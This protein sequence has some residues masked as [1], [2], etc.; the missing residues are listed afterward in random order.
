MD[1]VSS[2]RSHTL[3]GMTLRT[4]SKDLETTDVLRPVPRCPSHITSHAG[5]ATTRHTA[6]PPFDELSCKFDVLT[7]R[8]AQN[9]NLVKYSPNRSVLLQYMNWCSVDMVDGWCCNHTLS[10][11]G[12]GQ[13]RGRFT[14]EFKYG[15]DVCVYVYV[16]CVYVCMCGVCVCC[17]CVLCMCVVCAYVCACMCVVCVCVCVVCVCGVCV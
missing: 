1:K 11:S 6:S 4:S 13:H 8:A 7:A 15:K 10:V 2:I 5:P 12:W 14:I 16:W 9:R 17:V 3:N